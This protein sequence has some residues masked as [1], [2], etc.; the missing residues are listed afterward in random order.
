MV[1]PSKSLVRRRGHLPAHLR[2]RTDDASLC[3]YCGRVTVTVGRGSCAECW[4]PKTPGG[5]PVIASRGPRTE[6]FAILDV[7]DDLPGFAWI[8]ILFAALGALVTVV[9]RFL[10]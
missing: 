4:K 2:A 9:V 1:K 8:L 7:L 10:V 3:A 5:E 6:P